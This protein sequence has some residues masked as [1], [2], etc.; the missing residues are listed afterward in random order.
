MSDKVKSA[1]AV[2]LSVTGTKWNDE[3][4]LF[5]LGELAN[6]NE[7]ATLDAIRKAA[8]ECE[9]RL[10]LAAILERIIREPRDTRSLEHKCEPTPMPPYV[11]A[12]LRKARR[13]HR[14]PTKEAT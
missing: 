4:L 3:A 10:T 2:A 1:L 5:A 6:E 12:L 13:P 8:R 7:D 9:Y 14:R 11:R